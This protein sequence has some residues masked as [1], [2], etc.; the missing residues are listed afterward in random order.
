MTATRQIDFPRRRRLGILWVMLLMCGAA[1]ADVLTVGGANPQYRSIPEAIAAARPGD[2]IRVLPGAYV[3]QLTIDKS[4]K[5]EG[6]D[7]PT[8]RGTGHGSTIVIAADHCVL[9]GFKLEHCGGDLQAEDSGI[10]IKSNHN[11]IENNELSD[12]L[13]GIYLL[14][15]SHNTIRG[16]TVRGRRELEEGERGAGLHMWNSSDNLIEGNTILEARDGLY[17]QSSSRNTVRRNYVAHLRYGLHY[18]NSDDNRFDDNVF[19]NNVAGAAI[20]YSRRIEMRRN[21]F[22]HNRGFSSFGILFQDC[23]DILAEDNYLIDNATGIFM[24]ALRQ[25][26]FRR[27]VIAENDLALFIFSNSDATTVVDNNFIENLSPLQVVGKS[28]T[29]RWHQSGRGNYWSDYAGYDLDGNGI[30]DISHRVQNVFEYL[31]GNY[32]RLRLYLNSPAAQALAAAEKTFPL[33]RGS[34]ELD[35]A[36]LMKAVTLSIPL[37][38]EQRPRATT[39]AIYIVMSLLILGVSMSIIWKGQL[40]QPGRRGAK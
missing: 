16:N 22:L 7:R 11:L 9:K 38:M 24:E 18:M 15:A 17:I 13:Y 26:M 29:I 35:R 1:R 12:I 14:G 19:T 6:I 20:M 5:L 27:N 39:R 34:A 8:L 23:D 21:A 2:T 40:K 32:P 10:L 31:E 36:P 4:I 3:V 37:P 25:S 28:T 30:G 33:L